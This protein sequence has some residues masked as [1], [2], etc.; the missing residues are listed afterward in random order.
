LDVSYQQVLQI[1]GDGEVH[2]LPPGTGDYRYFFQKFVEAYAKY[3]QSGAAMYL[4][5]N[6]KVPNPDAPGGL[7]GPAP[8]F[9]D[10]NLNTDDF[11]FDSYGGNANKGEFIQWDFADKTHDPTGLLIEMLL[12]GTNLQTVHFY[13]RLD[14]EERALF[15]AM[16]SYDARQATD[17]NKN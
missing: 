11:F 10:Y 9:G 2:N 3:L 13:R 8:Y 17:Q 1:L 15:Q 12:I 5:Q 4:G 14:R 6:V 16:E 7:P